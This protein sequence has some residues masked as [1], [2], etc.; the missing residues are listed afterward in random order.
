MKKVLIWG[1]GKVAQRVFFHI[2]QTEEVVG[3]YDNNEEKNGE[4]LLGLPIWKFTQKK[5]DEKIVIA[6]SMWDEISEQL[7][8]IG[9]EPLVDYYPYWTITDDCFEIEEMLKLSCSFSTIARWIKEKKKICVVY[10][11]C[12]TNIIQQYLLHCKEFTNQYMLINIPRVCDKSEEYWDLIRETG[13][14]G[15]VDLLVYQSVSE[16]NK[17]GKKRA[18]DYIIN[19]LPIT[20]KKICIPNIY[21]DGY[22]PQLEKNERNVLMNIQ[23]DGLFKWG[24]MIVRELVA[25]GKTFDEVL[26][27]ISGEVFSK[28]EIQE[29]INRSFYNLKIREDKTDVIISDYI[30]KNYKGK[31][32][33]WSPNH[34]IN[35]VIFECTVR[36]LNKLGINKATI[37]RDEVDMRNTLKGEDIPIYPVVAR[38]LEIDI[39]GNS[40]FPN[41]YI[42][43][44]SYDFL[45]YYKLFYNV[46]LWTNKS[47]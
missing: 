22:F 7:N 38:F 5:P 46:A 44:K 31:A 42:E 47:K 9:L 12:Q 26:D 19:Q 33:F 20:A 3:W 32:L 34:P 18:S 1:T 13:V 36:I 21:F 2:F 17:Y 23:E 25:K 15:H 45:A 40:Y 11:N 14:F 16:S 29:H 39:L 8:E 10:G 6:S 4:L 30:E 35:D 24:D 37:L 43:Y 41:R 28:E 27:I